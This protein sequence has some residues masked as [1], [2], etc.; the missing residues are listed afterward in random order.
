ME[1]ISF[2]SRIISSFIDKILILILFIVLGMF[3]F[4]TPYTFP[5][6]FGT[7]CGLL[8]SNPSDY[9][10]I[11]SVRQTREQNM[12]HISIYYQ[13]MAE[14]HSSYY[15]DDLQTIDIEITAIFIIANFLYYL[16]TNLL[17]GASIGKRLCKGI[18]VTP[19]KKRINS[20]RILLRVFIL[21]LLISLL[22]LLRFGLNINYYI[23]IIVYFSMLVLFT[24]ETERTFVDCL[25]GTRVVKQ[26]NLHH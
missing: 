11:E 6:R 25:S 15:K 19:D 21:S 17:F 16:I 14:K 9:I 7:Y 24:I 23:I 26:D 5:G 13:H 18:I 10:K 2:S 4:Y 20:N 8:D 3:I 1:T 12:N 22:V